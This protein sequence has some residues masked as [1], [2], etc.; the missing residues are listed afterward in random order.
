M[1]RLTFAVAMIAVLVIALILGITL[2]TP[3]LIGAAMC[4]WTP[5]MLFSGYSFA[6]VGG[7]VRSPISMPR[8]AAEIEFETP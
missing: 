6:K 5:V 3:A 8:K 2:Q 4:L 1:K 7:K